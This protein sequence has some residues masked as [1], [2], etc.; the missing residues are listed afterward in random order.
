MSTLP[1]NIA[2]LL[3]AATPIVLVARRGRGHAGS[4][5]HLEG[6]DAQLGLLHERSSPIPR[7]MQDDGLVTVSGHLNF[8]GRHPSASVH[9]RRSTR[10]SVYRLFLARNNPR[11]IAIYPKLRLS[12]VNPLYAFFNEWGKSLGTCSSVERLESS[13]A[14]G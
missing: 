10:M 6:V 5:K 11:G 13:H 9:P 14:A 3:L 7:F 4:Q 12:N 1:Y 2:P 8:L